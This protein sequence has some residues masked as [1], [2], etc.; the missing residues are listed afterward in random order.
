MSSLS[1]TGLIPTR[2]LVLMAQLT[3]SITLLMDREGN[4]KA[5]LPY[6]HTSEQYIGKDTE[7]I[8]G[9]SLSIAFIAIELLTFGTGFT[10]FSN[11]ATVFSI[12]AHSAGTVALAYFATDIWDCNL[13]WWIFSLSVC[14]PL[15]TDISVIIVT[16]CAYDVKYK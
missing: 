12:M 1:G 6:D 10:M 2:Y 15:L 8:V 11:F 7:L 14:F 9:L 5:C 16:L 3:L 4:V 13:F